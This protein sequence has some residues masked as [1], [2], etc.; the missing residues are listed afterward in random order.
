MKVLVVGDVHGHWHA[1]NNVIEKTQPEII[2]QCGD[3]GY[4]PR[5]DYYS[6]D[7]LKNGNCKIYWCDGNH[8]D[9]EYLKKLESNEVA[10]NVFYMKRGS[11]L[12][13]NGKNILFMGGADSIDKHART[14]GHTWFPDELITQRDIYELPDIQVDIVISHTCPYE[15][16]VEKHR[17]RF[18]NTYDSSRDALHVI[19]AKYRP[20]R[21]FFGHWHGFA[22]GK[23]QNT[24]WWCLNHILALDGKRF[25]GINI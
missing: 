7:K 18:M 6:F 23:Y 12:T 11:Y 24:R 21:W 22:Q 16:A 17:G 9:H 2:F 13:L 3:F 19:L 5:N 25:M 14:P 1:L 4:W 8:E 20:S 15:F 10:P